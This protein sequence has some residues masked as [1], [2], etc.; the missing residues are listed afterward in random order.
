MFRRDIN[1][2]LNAYKS[3]LAWAD[4]SFS[5]AIACLNAYKMYKRWEQDLGTDDR[6]KDNWCR[7]NFIQYR[8]VRDVDFMFGDILTRLRREN[9]NIPERPNQRR[10]RHEEELILKV[11]D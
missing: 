6:A 11:L 4:R 3:R 7:Q 8:R 10:N 5:D 1:Q 2:G 9:I